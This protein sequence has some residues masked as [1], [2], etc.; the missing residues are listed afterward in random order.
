MAGQADVE[1]CIEERTVTVKNAATR[2]VK[3]GMEV[4]NQH[5]N[6]T[7]MEEIQYFL[8]NPALSFPLKKKYNIE[9]GCTAYLWLEWLD[10]QRCAGYL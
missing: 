7:I 9:F 10:W 8:E 1:G 2:H 4:N 6:Y 5:K 3:S